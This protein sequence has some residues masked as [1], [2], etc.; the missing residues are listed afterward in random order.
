MT[1]AKTLMTASLLAFSVA[2]GAAMAQNL[3]PEDFGATPRVAAS[4]TAAQA[5]GR[6]EGMVGH[7][8]GANKAWESRHAPEE[9][10]G[11]GGNG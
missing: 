9:L 1:I 11:N 4:P 10:E 2:S 5:T 7:L 6:D 8:V 3:T